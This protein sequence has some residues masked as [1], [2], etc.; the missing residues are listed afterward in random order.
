LPSDPSVEDQA[1]RWTPKS[2]TGMQITLVREKYISLKINSNENKETF[3][4]L[5][6]KKKT[7]F[8]KIA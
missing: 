7:K 2:Q 4:F 6:N 1:G 3:L 8:I 5:N